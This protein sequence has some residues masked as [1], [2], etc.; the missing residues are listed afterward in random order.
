LLVQ[1]LSLVGD[2]DLENGFEDIAAKEAWPVRE[3]TNI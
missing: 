3:T 2:I 1:W